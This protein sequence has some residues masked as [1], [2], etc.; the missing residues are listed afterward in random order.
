[1]LNKSYK[2]KES[3]ELKSNVDFIYDYPIQLTEIFKKNKNIAI[4]NRKLTNQ[5]IKSGQ[6]IINTNPKLAFSKIRSLT[7]IFFIEKRLLKDKKFFNL[8]IFENSF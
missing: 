5:L 3:R 7:S 4:W 1:M 6:S 8:P 2:L